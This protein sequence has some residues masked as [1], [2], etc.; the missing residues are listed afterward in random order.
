MSVRTR[1]YGSG[2]NMSWK[3]HNDVYPIGSI[4]AI[5]GNI[6]HQYTPF[7]LAYIPA[8]WIL[9]VLDISYDTTVVHLQS[10]S[11]VDLNVSCLSSEFTL[12]SS[13]I[14]PGP[15][16]VISDTWS[17]PTL[18][19]LTPDPKK[20]DFGGWCGKRTPEWFLRFGT[21]RTF[22]SGKTCSKSMEKKGSKPFGS[23]V[24]WK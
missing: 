9:W 23:V 4:Y 16:Q 24:E 19:F 13:E 15:S 12:K 6:Y 20:I 3:C 8:P 2:D 11:E 14:A 22:W 18:D 10:T 5:Y 21:L 7:M 1:E 17:F